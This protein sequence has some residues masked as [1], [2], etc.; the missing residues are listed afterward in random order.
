VV[1]RFVLAFLVCD[2]CC[3]GVAFA[4]ATMMARKDGIYDEFWFSGQWWTPVCADLARGRDGAVAR[5]CRD[6]AAVLLVVP[7]CNDGVKVV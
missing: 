7:I 5:S 1:V 3:D 6:V 2:C 4:G